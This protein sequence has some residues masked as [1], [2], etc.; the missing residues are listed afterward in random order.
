M[1]KINF[2]EVGFKNFL[3]TGNQYTIISLNTHFTTFLY[4]ENGSGKTTFADAISFAL[5]GKPLRSI[6]KP[7]LINSINN[8]DCEVY[9]KVSI[10]NVKY[11]IVRGI[12]PNKLEIYVDDSIE[13]IEP[14]AGREL[15]DWLE[16]L[17]GF[18]HKTYKHVVSLGNAS[19]TPF[20]QLSPKDR[21]ELVEDLRELNIF[22]NMAKIAKDEI[23]L[24]NKEFTKIES[25]YKVLIS[26]S[27]MLKG[28]IEQNEK[29]TLERK[30]VIE[31]DIK[32]ILEK[33][34]IQKERKNGLIE[35]GK[36]VSE[37]LLNKQI[38]ET[39]F[40]E[41]SQ[42]LQKYNNK[43]DSL[44][45]K[46]NNIVSIEK[47]ITCYQSVTKDHKHHIETKGKETISQYYEE[48]SI[49][50]EEYDILK[51]KCELYSV[52]SN[53]LENIRED[54]LKINK[55]LKTWGEIV[56]KYESMI[57]KIDFS[58]TSIETRKLE[59]KTVV[60]EI[61]DV[62]EKC[63]IIKDKIQI[64]TD[65]QRHLKDDGIKASII[66]E[67]I[68]I[69]NTLVNKYLEE[70]DFFVRFELDYEFNETIKS[71]HR[72]T[73]S[74]YSFSEG[75]KQRIDVAIMLAWRELTKLSGSDLASILILDEV[76]D[77]SLDQSA[78]D[79]LIEMIRN[80]DNNVFII[81]HKP[82]ESFGEVDRILKFQKINNYSV[83]S[84]EQYE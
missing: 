30:S 70:L 56:E 33:T 13:S 77:S 47:C 11:K 41:L 83:M 81:S 15:Q 23:Y 16:S 50:K 59:L 21:R 40:K 48:I 53:I 20:L 31:N 55:D 24:L 38:D 6:N 62:S 18:T 19:Y 14:P 5:Y 4:G 67:F 43:I 34:N 44:Q 65:C 82:M 32:E 76:F 22:A 68:P 64:L 58:N 78:V 80:V 60:D 1:P 52:N 39:R 35:E 37:T 27:E 66:N 36:K 2:E 69:F 17:I 49:I 63:G 57:L 74:Y 8:S 46:M 26:K 61:K 42:L 7:Q 51:N 75:E 79:L 45:E 29:E 71:R 9:L 3:S 84:E 28:F 25:D 72:D 73:F 10:G 12:K 54:I